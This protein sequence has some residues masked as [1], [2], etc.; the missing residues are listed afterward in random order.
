MR[1]IDRHLLLEIIFSFFQIVL[2]LSFAQ[3]LYIMSKKS[4]VI[5]CIEPMS[6]LFKTLDPFLFCAY[7]VD[8]FPAGDNKMRAPRRGNGADFNPNAPYRMY[9]GDE[10]PGFPQVSLTM[11]TR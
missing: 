7:H 11:L 4:S 10:I 1:F 8:E 3:S 2:S 5:S 9:H 6:G